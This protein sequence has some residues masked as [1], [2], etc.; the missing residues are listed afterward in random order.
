MVYVPSHRNKRLH[1]IE[2]VARRRSLVAGLRMAWSEPCPKFCCGRSNY[3]LTISHAL[4]HPLAAFGN[5]FHRRILEPTQIKGCYTPNSDVVLRK[6][7]RRRG[8]SAC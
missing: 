2:H 6:V 8:V 4:Q 5:V 7:E 3:F 1:T